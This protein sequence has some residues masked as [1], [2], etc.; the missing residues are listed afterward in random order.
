[1]RESRGARSEAWWAVQADK[2]IAGEP[3]RLERQRSAGL[4]GRRAR[5]A[6]G[7]RPPEGSHGGFG[8][9]GASAGAGPGGRADRG[10]EGSGAGRCCGFTAPGRERTARAAQRVSD[11]SQAALIHSQA[12]HQNGRL[13]ARSPELEEGSCQPGSCKRL[14][15]SSQDNSTHSGPLPWAVAVVLD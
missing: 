1:M 14:V 11:V 13:G 4:E 10:L 5:H 12:D 9:A 6:T 2:E 8:R 7:R 15:H 3:G